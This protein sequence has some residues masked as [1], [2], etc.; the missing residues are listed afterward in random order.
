MCE[1]SLQRGARQYVPV[2][3]LVKVLH[4]LVLFVTIEDAVFAFERVQE[5]LDEGLHLLGEVLVELWKVDAK[6]LLEFAHRRAGL[7]QL[8]AAAGRCA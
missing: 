5:A 3:G 2:D 8:A 7:V 1:T 4:D 6:L